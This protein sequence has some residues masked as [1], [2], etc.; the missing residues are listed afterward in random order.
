MTR[1]EYFQVHELAIF[2]D[3]PRRI[4]KKPS[5]A[6]VG[7]QQKFRTIPYDDYSRSKSNSIAEVVRLSNLLTAT[8]LTEL[9]STQRF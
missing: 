8:S 5:S 3:G 4:V 1:S 7:L 9:Y 2:I 6:D